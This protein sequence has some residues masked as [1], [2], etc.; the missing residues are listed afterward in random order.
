MKETY[1][2]VLTNYNLQLDYFLLFLFKHQ[3]NISSINNYRINFRL[4]FFKNGFYMLFNPSESIKSVFKKHLV[5]FWSGLGYFLNFFSKWF[6]PLL[7]S[8]IF[9]YY[10]LIIKSLPLNKV[11][12]VWTALFMT[13]YWIISGFVFF[14]KKYQYAKF[15]S[16]IQRFW[17]R[18]LILFWLIE[19]GLL[20][21]FVFLTINSTWYLYN[22]VDQTQ[23]F[24]THFFSWRLF[25]L[26]IFPVTFLI[27]ISYIFLI[28]NKWQSLNKNT[29]LL[30]LI[31]GLL[32]YI[33]WNEFYQ[34]FHLM[35]YYG[36]STW[37]YDTT[38]RLW[39]INPDMKKT[40]QTN[41]LVSLL[42]ILKFWHVL[43]ILGVWLF[44]VLRSDESGRIRYPLVAGNILNFIMLYLLTWVYMYPWFKWFF[45]RYFSYSYKWFYQNNRSLAL[46][47]FFNDIKLFYTGL[48]NFNC[49]ELYTLNGFFNSFFFYFKSSDLYHG[50]VDFNKKFHQN[51]IIK[52]FLFWESVVSHNKSYF[53]NFFSILVEILESIVIFFFQEW[54]IGLNPNFPRIN[55]W[56]EDIGLYSTEQVA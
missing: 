41:H 40:S 24:K 26:K 7:L 23:I 28:N 30:I 14:Y 44:L 18:T 12:F 39:V 52:D 16:I 32:L 46:R 15:T 33:T 8:F 21:V 43:F 42:L 47:L 38:I 13:V 19:G 36:Q 35:N 50:S 5:F 31:T 55:K 27:V 34:F 22:V 25:L 56:V 49:T 17:K 9:V 51:E 2:N 11:L 37:L 1:L 10:S 29:F 53:S 3:Y 20:I 4:N 54:F 6:L 48:I 45:R